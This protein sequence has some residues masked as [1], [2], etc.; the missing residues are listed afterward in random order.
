LVVLPEGRNFES[1]CTPGGDIPVFECDFGKLGIQICYHMEFDY[2]WSELARKGRA[3]LI[4]F[5]TQSP[6]TSQPACRAMHN[7]CYIVSTTWRS[8]ASVFE[9]TGK[10]AAQVLP[11][12]RILVHEM[13]LSYAILP[14][15]PNLKKGEAMRARYG[16]K[17][18]FRY[19]DDEDC[20]IFWSNDSSL[21]V[22]EMA[23][24]IGVPE[25]DASLERV[26]NIY[27]DAS[28]IGYRYGKPGLC[29]FTT[30]DAGESQVSKSLSAENAVI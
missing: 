29:A 22:S 23:N 9:P 24:S 20:G 7:R 11:P 28:V 10:I 1:G 6:Q 19:Y 16:S 17:V 13:D 30:H 18:G 21:T 3:E 14:W 26:R 4:V 5:P 12:E 25:A 15:H 8:N 2:G 27:H